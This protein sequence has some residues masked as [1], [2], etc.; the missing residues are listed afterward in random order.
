MKS[1]VIKLPINHTDRCDS[2]LDQRSLA[3]RRQVVEVLKSSRRGHLGSTFSLMEILR[4][5]YDD[6]LRFDARNPKWPERDRCILSKGHGCLALYVMLADRGFF[7]KEELKHF[8]AHDGILGGHPDHEKVP[9]VEASTGSLGHGLSIGVGMALSARME[10]SQRRV[11][12]IVGDGECNEGAVWEAALSAGNRG[13]DN[14]CVLIDYNKYQSYD[15]T[16][17]VQDLEPLAAKWESFGFGVIEVDGHNVNG[18][19][20]VLDLL[21]LKP[22]KPSVVICHTVKGKGIDFTENNLVWHH[23]SN[24]TDQQIDAM[25]ASLGG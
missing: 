19:R 25:T 9:G 7:P 8:C 5:L 22:G 3:L 13:L 10:G 12:V 2:A 23:K 14:L 11:F 4:V 20:R 15:R 21:P 1:S 6:V 24:I 16:A 17:V 18:L